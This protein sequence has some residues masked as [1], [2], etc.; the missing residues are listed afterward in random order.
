VLEVNGAVD[1]R[2]LYSLELDVHDAVLHAL[3]KS[4]ETWAGRPAPA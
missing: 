2:P 1:V 3:R 4:V